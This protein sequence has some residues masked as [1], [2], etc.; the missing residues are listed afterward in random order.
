MKSYFLVA[1]PTRCFSSKWLPFET[2]SGHTAWIN[3]PPLFAYN[4]RCTHLKSIKWL[5][6]NGLGMEP[7]AV[8]HGHIDSSNH[9]VSAKK[10]N[11]LWRVDWG[12]GHGQ[13]METNS[14]NHWLE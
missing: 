4:A 13:K 7:G 11:V 1:I 5:W 3:T 14:P 9:G 8:H 2:R 6:C 10:A 12:L